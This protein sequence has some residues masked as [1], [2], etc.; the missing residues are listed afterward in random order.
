[1]KLLRLSNGRKNDLSR[2]NGDSEDTDTS[3]S[4]HFKL[5]D[6]FVIGFV[7]I[8]MFGYKNI[9]LFVIIILNCKKVNGETVL[10]LSS[11]IKCYQ[12]WQWFGMVFLFVW[13]IPFPTTLIL[14]YK[15]MK[16][17]SFGKFWF[18]ISLLF[19]PLTPAFMFYTRNK[20]DVALVQAQNLIDLLYEVFEEPYRVTTTNFDNST[21]IS[22]S[23]G[24]S[25]SETLYWW[26][27]WR[28]YERLLV[29]VITTFLTQPIIR[30]SVII[31][32]VICLLMFHVYV[33]PYKESMPVL[34]LLDMSCLA[35]LMVHAG[36]NFVQLFT[37]TF[38]VLPNYPIID[39]K[40]LF[41]NL[42][43]AFTPISFLGYYIFLNIMNVLKNKI[44]SLF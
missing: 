4:T 25:K 17:G 41:T 26:N 43:F 24:N 22:N 39:T 10:F 38:Q 7:K 29:V 8:L 13:V 3:N 40:T 33:K 44:F 12:G 23:D 16:Q 19:P 42:K 27:A 18:S 6:R 2:H 5:M 20:K 36:S 30:I 11:D 28:L 34:T 35:C 21:N 31:P 32:L 1:M 9:S 14:S 37:T 15:L